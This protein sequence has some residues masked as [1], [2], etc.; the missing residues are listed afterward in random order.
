MYWV[1]D[2]EG[3]KVALKDG[4]GIAQAKLNRIKEL[5]GGKL[6]DIVDNNTIFYSEVDW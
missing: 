1:K 4:W 3:E 2:A 5:A 6:K